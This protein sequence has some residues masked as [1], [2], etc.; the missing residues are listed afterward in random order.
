MGKLAAEGTGELE[1]MKEIG[2]GDVEIGKLFGERG[3]ELVDD[4]LGNCFD[5]KFSPGLRF[6]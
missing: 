2:L 3:Q 1:I 4:Y 6:W 5:A